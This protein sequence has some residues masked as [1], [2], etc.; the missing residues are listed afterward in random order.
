MVIFDKDGASK[1]AIFTRDGVANVD[2][3]LVVVS[4]VGSWRFREPKKFDCAW[5]V[6]C[7]APADG[8]WTGGGGRERT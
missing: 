7:V 8:V 1:R 6:C 5:R 3:K 4:C 2:D